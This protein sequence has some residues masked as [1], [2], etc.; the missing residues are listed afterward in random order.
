MLR[1][2]LSATSQV[3]W[4]Y[5]GYMLYVIIDTYYHYFGAVQQISD[6]SPHSGLRR[7]LAAPFQVVVL[8]IRLRHVGYTLNH[9]PQGWVKH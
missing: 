7:P 3:Y 4:K 2:C 9:S 6:I 1:L 5:Y 8:H